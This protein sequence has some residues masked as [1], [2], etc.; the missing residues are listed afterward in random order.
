V[1][2]SLWLAEAPART[3]PGSP[4]RAGQPTVRVRPP[5][6]LLAP[7][8]GQGRPAGV[9]G[10]WSAWA[11]L[12]VL[13]LAVAAGATAY[14][15]FLQMPRALW[16]SC[17]HDRNAH[18]CQGLNFALSFRHGDLLQFLHEFHGARVWGPMHGLLQGVVLAVGGLDFRFAVLPSLA[19]WMLAAVFAFLAARRSAG[20]GGTVAGLVAALFVLSSP[21]HHAFATDIMIESL[22]ACLSLLALYL[23]LVAIQ[24]EGLW[25]SRW[26]GLALTALFTLKYNYYLLVVFALLATAVCTRPRHYLQILAALRWPSWLRRQLG[27]PITYVI[28]LGLA[29]VAWIVLTGGGSIDAGGRQI[30]L[31]S[32]HNVIFLVYVLLFLRGLAWW[33]RHG[34][35][36]T[37]RLGP[38]GRQLVYWHVWPVAVW[39]LWPKRLSYCLWFVGPA[40]AGEHPQHDLLGGYALYPRWLAADYHAGPWALLLVV[41]LVALAVW[42]ARRLR[43]G[44]Q[45]FLWFVLIAAVITFHHPN[46]KSRFLHSWIGGAWVAAGIGLA[47]ALHG[48]LTAG[49][50]RWRPWLSSATAGGLAVALLPGVFAQGHAP[51]GGPNPLRPCTLDLTDAYLPALKGMPHVAI[52]SNMP[53][54]HLAR[55]TLTQ[56]AGRELAVETEVKGQAAAP[57]QNRQALESWLNSTRSEAVVCIDI[58]PATAFWEESPLPC[59]DYRPLEQLLACRQDY[60]PAGH[61]DFPRYGCSI[62][63]WRRTAG[64]VA[65]AR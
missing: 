57:G 32:P 37:A 45:V 19:A 22:G 41:G 42:T 25:P 58:P 2:D 35:S 17:T 29:V 18:F 60:C 52:L 43:P 59:P 31:T 1:D 51:E 54:K 24:D 6:V 23:F 50:P 46:R 20:R 12:L 48:K 13:T 27:R 44:G 63:M 8:P 33:R 34:R 40:N 16:G 21:A 36:L 38:R 39:F 4:S 5:E 64:K 11:P 65:A 28:G 61:W 47:H 49:R 10:R 26:L 30:S 56:Q 9:P 3:L 7:T 53:L 14:L 15:R 62:R 55:W